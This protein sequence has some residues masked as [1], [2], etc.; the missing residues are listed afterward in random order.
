LRRAGVS[1]FPL[2]W[3]V[4]G[5][6]F[7]FQAPVAGSPTP[8]TWATI[9]AEESTYLGYVTD[10]SV[11][12]VAVE[13]EAGDILDPGGSLG[14]ARVRGTILHQRVRGAGTLTAR[15]DRGAFAETD[16][17]D[18]FED[19][20][21]EPASG[22]VL[23]GYLSTLREGRSLLE[24]GTADY[25]RHHA[26]AL[27]DPS[28]LNRH[29]FLCGQS[30]SGKSYALGLILE[31]LLAE[32]SLRL[33]V[34]D[35]NGDFV[36]LGE[37]EGTGEAA[38][39]LDG[40]SEDLS[41]LRTTGTEPLRVRAAD[42]G[43]AEIA[44]LA[45]IDPVGDRDEYAVF[46]EFLEGI[47]PGSDVAD[48]TAVAAQGTAGADL[49]TRL[50]NL[51]L[52]QWHVWARGKPSAVE[53]LDRNRG[54]V[55]ADLSGLDSDRERWV[56]A[57]AL[58]GH[59]WDGREDRRPT[60]IVADEAHNL[61]PAAGEDPL[62]RL[63]A[64][65]FV[66]VAAEGRKYGLYLLLSTQRPSKVHP[67]AASQAENLILMKVN[68]AA[69]REELSAMFSHIPPA[70]I[71]RAGAFRKGEALIGGPVVEAPMFL[72]FGG[73]LSAEPGGDVPTGWASPP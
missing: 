25:G 34:L 12:E 35:P 39:R 16:T 50:G 6:T 23:D 66:Q 59:L 33:V 52:L 19:A 67:N 71:G 68:S 1:V 69:D 43:P 32:T 13:V 18:A 22:D 30:G 17:T 26:P 38:V 65:R 62:H 60:L 70:L 41:V 36:R 58:L 42:L 14:S 21:I 28:G 61:C 3:S 55:V 73:R 47:S 11:D 7:G 31:R 46:T 57:H 37:T 63:L 44:A 8:G 72:R 40:A 29:A 56:V 2:A 5:V 54:C 51:G 48:L 53:A 64:E 24:V 49:A 10:A 4:D 20:P 9:R 45:R 15:V 27:L